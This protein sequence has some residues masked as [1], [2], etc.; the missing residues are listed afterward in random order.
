[1]LER[2][3]FNPTCIDVLQEGAQDI[4]FMIDHMLIKLGK[5]LRILGYDAEWDLSLRTHE[6][7]TR[8]NLENRIF[9]T[10]NAHLDGRYPMPARRLVLRETDP[11]LQLEI[12]VAE[13]GLDV[14]ARLFSKCIRCNVALDVVPDKNAIRDRVHPHT[15]A[16][17]D[18]FYSCP[19]CGTVF[20]KGSHVR[21]TCR[22]LRLPP[23]AS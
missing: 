14:Q 21:N 4:R 20:W 23:A 15:F 22:K 18:R 17:Y 2:G 12:V 7:I 11:V 19:R 6:L 5:Y 16:Q 10:R 9:V 8:A 13:F 3:M 1:M